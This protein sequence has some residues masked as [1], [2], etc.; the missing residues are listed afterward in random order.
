VVVIAKLI[1]EKGTES[2]ML[3]KSCGYFKIMNIKNLGS[4]TA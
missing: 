1:F 3:N 2:G 4:K